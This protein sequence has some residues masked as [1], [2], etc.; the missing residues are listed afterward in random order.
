MVICRVDHLFAPECVLNKL[1][2]N[3][4][5]DSLR[6]WYVYREKACKEIL[7]KPIFE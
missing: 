7:E 2:S 6:T 5:A 1:H 4:L 3:L